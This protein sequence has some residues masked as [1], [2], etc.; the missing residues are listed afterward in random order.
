MNCSKWAERQGAQENRQG[1]M[2]RAAATSTT[3]CRP[4]VGTQTLVSTEGVHGFVAQS[5]RHHPTR[6]AVCCCVLLMWHQQAH[7]KLTHMQPQPRATKC[8]P[9]PT[10]THTCVKL[11]NSPRGDIYVPTNCVPT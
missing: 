4:H 6:P 8:S 9:T 3:A 5:N 1:I 10:H 2:Q 7:T 11:I